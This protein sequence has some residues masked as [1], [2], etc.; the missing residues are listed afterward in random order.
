M[1]D[2]TATQQER[3]TVDETQ[4]DGTL[5][6]ENEL[7]GG[8]FPDSPA[9]DRVVPAPQA[10]RGRITGVAIENPKDGGG[11]PFLK[12]SCKSLE[13]AADDALAV[14]LPVE[15]VNNV[16]V[17][18]ATLSKEETVTPNGNKAPSP[19]AKYGQT[20]RN[21]GKTAKDGTHIPGDGTLE[22]LIRFATEQGHSVAL[23]T[24]RT[25]EQVANYLNSLCTG[26][27]VVALMR[28]KGGDGEF[29]DRLRTIR[30]VDFTYAD[31]EKSL[32]DYRKLWK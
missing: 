19:Y 17:D 14:F 1:M 16:L 21:S 30:F 12:I 18:P 25:F 15:Y 4:V 23:A 8:M 13:T 5:A 32:K 24:P 22:T 6:A 20:V 27:E 31:G 26:T 28:A 2:E 7:P 3:E 10:H 9:P 11:T 29:A